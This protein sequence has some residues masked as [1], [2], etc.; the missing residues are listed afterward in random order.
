MRTFF[1]EVKQVFING[2]RCLPRNSSNCTIL[3]SWVFDNSI[4]SDEL[5]A[6]ALQNLETRI[7]VNISSWVKFVSS[8]E[9]SITFNEKI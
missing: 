8:L 4:L 5:F 7:T 2:L 9:S 3:D 6:K 1:I